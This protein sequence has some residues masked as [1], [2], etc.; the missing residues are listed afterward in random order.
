[1]QFLRR[2]NKNESEINKKDKKQVIIQSLYEV[3]KKERA[4]VPK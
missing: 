1:M 3:L 2:C 4:K